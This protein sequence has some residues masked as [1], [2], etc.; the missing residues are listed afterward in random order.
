MPISKDQ[1]RGVIQRLSRGTS[2]EA[3]KARMQPRHE[4]E[5][6]YEPDVP[7]PSDSTAT[8]RDARREYL[9][10]AH[11]E[12]PHLSGESPPPDPDE[13][14]GNIEQFIGMAQV[15]VGLAGPI[16]I[17][18]LHAHGDYLVTLA[19]T[20]GALV[21]SYH[22]GARLVTRAGGVSCLLTAEQ[23]QRAPG[24]VFD[25]LADAAQFAAWVTGEFEAFKAVAATRTTHGELV[26]LLVHME[27]RNVYVILAFYT[28]DA[29][30]QNMVTFCADAICADI[31]ARTP[32][33]PREWFLESNM[34]GDKKATVMS[35][36]Q[37][38]GRRVMAEVVLPREL[39]ERGLHTTPERM[40]TYWRLSFIGGVQSGSIGV[41]GHVANGLA[42]MFL[43]TGQDVACVSEASVGITHMELTP[44]GDLYC[45]LDLPNLIV[46]TVGGGTR[47]PTAREC[48]R[49]MRCEGDGKAAKFAE[50][51][52]GTLLAG[53]ISIIGALCAGHFA[54]S[55]ERLGRSTAS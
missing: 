38:R 7:R 43:A 36:M 46:G 22:R 41:S 11:I 10:R 19:T 5:K 15:P 13:L 37:T 53:E 18:G 29:S 44:Q 3:L 26:D 4:D 30:G 39:V 28:G 54:R 16:R 24:F 47:M 33:Q 35:F 1:A 31:L 21:A 25:G 51:I 2:L 42:A 48:L 17:N 9:R 20:E 45:G 34:S 23:V 8:G 27:S 40:T 12:I 14:R 55:H 52:A 6:P 49:I 50:I 32:V